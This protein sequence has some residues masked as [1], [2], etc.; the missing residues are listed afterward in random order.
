MLFC[1]DAYI[2]DSMKA[3]CVSASTTADQTTTDGASET[4]HEFKDTSTFTSDESD[5][6]SDID[7]VE[8]HHSVALALK[9]V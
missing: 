4:F 8:V 6:L 2:I 9:D 1:C 7:D 5:G 3:H